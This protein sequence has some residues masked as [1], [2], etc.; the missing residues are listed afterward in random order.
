M[1]NK[2]V[3]SQKIMLAFLKSATASADGQ[4]CE[5]ISSKVKQSSEKWPL[6]LTKQRYHHILTLP[7][8]T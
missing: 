7:P 8:V 2:M 4:I 1:Y 3:K 6:D 5:R